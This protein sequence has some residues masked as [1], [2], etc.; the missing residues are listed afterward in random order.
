MH[1]RKCMCVF[2]YA[3]SDRISL[4]FTHMHV[5]MHI[6]TMQI[7]ADNEGLFGLVEVEADNKGTYV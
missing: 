3:W 1:M 7:V 6:S 5:H 4:S 2:V